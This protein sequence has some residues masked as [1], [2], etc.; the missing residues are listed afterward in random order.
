MVVSGD[1]G[2]Q[3]AS[4]AYRKGKGWKISKYLLVLLTEKMVQ[5]I[6]IYKF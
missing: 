3:I 1:V 6:Q 5:L 4:T 2:F